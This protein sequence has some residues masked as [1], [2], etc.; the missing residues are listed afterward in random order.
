MDY[1]RLVANSSYVVVS[2]DVMR[3]CGIDAALLLG[4]LAQRQNQHGAGFWATEEQLEESTCLSPYRI[5]KAAA[6]L[7]EKGVLRVERYGL[8]A[9]KRYTILNDGLHA[10]FE[11]LGDAGSAEQEVKDFDPQLSKNFTTVGQKTSQHITN[12]INNEITNEKEKDRKEKAKEIIEYLNSKT[13]SGYRYSKASLTPIKARLAEGFTVEDCE[14]VIDTKAE[15]W[16]GTEMERYLRP[17]TLFSAS[18]FEGYLNQKPAK[19]EPVQKWKSAAEVNADR[20]RADV[21]RSLRVL[22]PEHGADALAEMFP[23]LIE[24]AKRLGLVEEFPE[25]EKF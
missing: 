7:A 1:V 2:R 15:E 5:R 19:K 3:A 25:L 11:S 8:P 16:G 17:Q 21:R 18:K 10:L 24:D 9:K 23:L 4:E 20:E 22:L 6:A 12:E 13:G 14:R